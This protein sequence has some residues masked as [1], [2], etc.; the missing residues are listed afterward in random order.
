MLRRSRYII[1]LEYVHGKYAKYMGE[2]IVIYENSLPRFYSVLDTFNLEIGEDFESFEGF[3]K[4]LIK[5][6]FRDKLQKGINEESIYYECDR[7]SHYNDDTFTSWETVNDKLYIGE[8]IF[9][10]DWDD[11]FGESIRGTTFREL[12]DFIADNQLLFDFKNNEFLFEDN[13]SNQWED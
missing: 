3:L 10:V 1:S 2:R 5:D 6:V 9:Y 13:R 7:E 11:L 12:F 4:F 8:E